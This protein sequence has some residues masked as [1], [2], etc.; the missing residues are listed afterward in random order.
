[1]L[2]LIDLGQNSHWS[3][4]IQEYD[5]FSWLDYGYTCIVQL[6]CHLWPFQP[7]LIGNKYVKAILTSRVIFNIIYILNYIWSPYYMD[8]RPEYNSPMIVNQSLKEWTQSESLLTVSKT[9]LYN[10]IGSWNAM[11]I[12]NIMHHWITPLIF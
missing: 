9:P 7:L 4:N 1:M 8:H 11:N 10:I 2:E 12:N 3:P 6:I 5:L